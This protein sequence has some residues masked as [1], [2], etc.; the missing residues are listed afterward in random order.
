MDQFRMKVSEHKSTSTV[1]SISMKDPIKRNKT[2]V[3]CTTGFFCYKGMKRFV[4][5]SHIVWLGAPAESLNLQIFLKLLESLIRFP[6]RMSV[7]C[8]SDSISTPT[9]WRRRIGYLVSIGHF[10]Q[11]SR[12]ISVS[13][14]ERDLQTK[15]SS[16]FSPTSTVECQT[17]TAHLQGSQDL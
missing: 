10:P 9:W 5:A 13:F 8:V 7:S 6:L 16:A 15:A 12:I 11:K 4:L 14:A 2:N 1:M 17:P 3:N